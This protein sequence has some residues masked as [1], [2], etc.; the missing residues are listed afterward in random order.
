M[1]NAPPAVLRPIR[2]RRSEQERRSELEA[3]IKAIDQRSLARTKSDLEGLAKSAQTIATGS[4]GKPWAKE[5][6]TAA[7]FLGQA[8]SSIKLEQ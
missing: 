5:V 4:S 6:A 8:A 1:S 2:R 7:N 3:K